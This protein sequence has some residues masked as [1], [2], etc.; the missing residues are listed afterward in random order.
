MSRRTQDLPPLRGYRHVIRE[1]RYHE[2][3]RQTLA[4]VLITLFALVSEPTGPVVAAGATLILAGTLLRLYASGFITKNEQLAT[5]GPY[6][7]VRHPLYTG[8]LLIIGGFAVASGV[9]WSVAVAVLFFWFYYPPAIEY[10]DRKLRGLFGAQW[11][12][13]AAEVPALIPRRA[14][15]ARVAAGGWS[16]A[17]CAKRNGEPFIAVFTVTWLGYVAW[18]LP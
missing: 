8:N 15:P 5:D 11:E 2:A 14:N 12:R 13:W 18:Q 1:L 10:E 16:L 6:A 4:F 17:K 7:L 3:S 9:W